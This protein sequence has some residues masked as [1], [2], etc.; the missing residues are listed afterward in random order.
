M[1]KENVVNPYEHAPEIFQAFLAVE[2]KIGASG[3]NKTLLHL[4][5]LRASQINQCAYCVDMHIR[6]ALADGDSQKRI[7]RVIVWR[8]VDD[9]S[10]AERA[11][12]AWTEALTELDSQA[13]L[14]PYR[15]ELKKYFSERDIA[16]MITVIG[17]I[18]LWN[19]VQVSQH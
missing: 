9:F 1:T 12:L 15:V 8:H 16:V 4:I 19:R 3:F 5:K 17:M 2:E 7:D 10:D 18:N 11:A 6:E 13:D 14:E